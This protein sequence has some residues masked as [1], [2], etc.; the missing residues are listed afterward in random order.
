MSVLDEI[1]ESRVGVADVLANKRKF[2]IRPDVDRDTF[3]EENPGYCIY[4]SV[5]CG[6]EDGS[7]IVLEQY[8]NKLSEVYDGISGY[9]DVLGCSPIWVVTLKE[10]VNS[11]TARGYEIIFGIDARVLSVYKAMRVLYG[12]CSMLWWENGRVCVPV[13]VFYH[14]NGEWHRSYM[15]YDALSEFYDYVHNHN[16]KG[17]YG[18]WKVFAMKL[19]GGRPREWTRDS[20]TE[21]DRTVRM[22]SAWYERVFIRPSGVNFVNVSENGVYL[23][24][25]RVSRSGSIT[26]NQS[27]FERYCGQFLIG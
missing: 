11:F 23:D 22:F 10:S 14:H 18:A 8:E 6:F 27:D 12:L 24:S 4:M 19:V 9:P 3:L 2:S 17:M 26:T 7:E 15:R 21:F 25:E 20:E 1:R 16:M 13:A 5:V